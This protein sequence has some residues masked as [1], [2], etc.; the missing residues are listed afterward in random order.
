MRGG[1][2]SGHEPWGKSPNPVEWS[3]NPF[4]L[5]TLQSTK[6]LPPNMNKKSIRNHKEMKTF[7]CE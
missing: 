6:R 3:P 4:T 2:P 5:D 1:R 7:E